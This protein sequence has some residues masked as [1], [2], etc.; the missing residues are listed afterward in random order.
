MDFSWCQWARLICDIILS[1]SHGM[2]VR[3]G[4]AFSIART[5]A[6]PA[7]EST[8]PTPTVTAFLL[9]SPQENRHPGLPLL[10]REGCSTPHRSTHGVRDQDTSARGVC[11][12]HHPPGP[13]KSLRI[14]E[15]G[16]LPGWR[17]DGVYGGHDQRG[18]PIH[19]ISVTGPMNAWSPSV[20]LLSKT[21]SDPS[22]PV[23]PAT[24]RKVLWTPACQCTE[25]SYA[26][27]TQGCSLS[28][29]QEISGCHLERPETG[30]PGSHQTST[31]SKARW[32][33]GRRLA[34]AERRLYEYSCN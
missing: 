34:K 13:T 27:H 21:C 33:A 8:T 6:R 19:L 15:R 32:S 26:H 17:K 18:S 25:H 4:L 3:H 12:G 7:L 10:G 9:V 23:C 24:T 31:S 14:R 16:S 29:P 5:T 28:F 22:C 2:S 20:G 11:S 30:L 1:R